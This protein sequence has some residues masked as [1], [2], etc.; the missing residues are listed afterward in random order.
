MEVDGLEATA[1][2]KE[3]TTISK[4]AAHIPAQLGEKDRLELMSFC[5]ESTRHLSDQQL[6]RLA[7]MFRNSHA[8][9]EARKL[10]VFQSGFG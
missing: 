7:L 1:K 6:F 8:D 9:G 10:L 2:T 4:D 5:E 3:I